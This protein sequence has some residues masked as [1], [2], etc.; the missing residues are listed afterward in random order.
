[1]QKNTDDLNPEH[2]FRGQSSSL[3]YENSILIFPYF[4]ACLQDYSHL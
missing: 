3:P 1:M 2:G 4:M